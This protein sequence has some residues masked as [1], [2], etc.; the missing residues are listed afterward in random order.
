MVR[1]PFHETLYAW[2]HLGEHNYIASLTRDA[3]GLQAAK[4]TAIA[5]NQPKDLE[6]ERTDLLDRLGS[7]P[8][9]DEAMERGRKMIEDLNRIEARR[10][11]S[12][13]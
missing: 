10:E 13:D 4:R 2:Y 6:Q 7:L 1:E 11:S 12:G 3:E 5:F 9:A 8:S